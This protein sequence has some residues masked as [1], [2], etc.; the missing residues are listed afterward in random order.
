MTL[1]LR[2]P[3][4]LLTVCCLLTLLAG[5][6][7]P[8]APVASRWLV[9]PAVELIGLRSDGA[10]LPRFVIAVR[11]YN[12]NPVTLDVAGVAVELDVNGLRLAR[13]L[14]NRRVLV[15]PGAAAVLDVALAMTPRDVERARRSGAR[16]R[17]GQPLAYAIAGQIYLGNDNRINS[18]PFTRSALI[19]PR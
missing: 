17:P 2:S 3:L 13:G 6:A 4:P 7:S 5:C 8:S 1:P 19:V 18:V 16:V 14:S 10:A 11:L 9:A 12:P 15:A